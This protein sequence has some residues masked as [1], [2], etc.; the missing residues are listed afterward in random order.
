MKAG[1]TPEYSGPAPEKPGNAQYSYEFAGWTP[2]VVPVTEDATYTALYTETIN[3]YTVTWKNADGTVLETDKNVPY[4]TTPI[5]DGADP[6][7]VPDDGKTYIFNGWT[8]ELS[9]VV[10]DATYTAV[11]RVYSAPVWS[12]ADD[13]SSASAFFKC[14]SGGSDVTV[15]A[16]VTSTTTPASCETAGET[17]YTASALFEGHTYMHS[18]SVVIQALG[19]DLEHH[20]AK[21]ATCT[22]I[23]WEAY[24]TCKR[25]D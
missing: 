18:E 19:H 12:W 7:M 3:A 23:G 4:G 9:T 14:E 8:P 16:S 21:A 5:Y 17:V 13:Y 1:I 24:D 11:Y 10:G 22:E 6:A 2:D 25:C 15:P 20:E